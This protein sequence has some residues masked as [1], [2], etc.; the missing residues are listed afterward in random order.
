MSARSTTSEIAGRL[1]A[2]PAPGAFDLF[3]TDLQ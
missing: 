1:K 2:Q 3:Q